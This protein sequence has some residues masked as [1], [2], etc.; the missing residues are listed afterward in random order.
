[1]L[2]F[3]WTDGGRRFWSKLSDTVRMFLIKILPGETNTLLN[4]CMSETVQSHRSK[5][6]THPHLRSGE[7]RQQRYGKKMFTCM[8]D[9]RRSIACD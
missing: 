5:F 3:V 7:A 9:G 8:K 1:M 4:S 2:K 6:P